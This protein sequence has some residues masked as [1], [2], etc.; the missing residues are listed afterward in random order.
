MFCYSFESPTGMTEQIDNDYDYDNDN[1]FVEHEHET[2][3]RHACE[4]R[5]PGFY[6]KTLLVFKLNQSTHT[7]LLYLN[8]KS[9]R[10]LRLNEMLSSL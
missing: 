5:H 9:L 10:S 4:G 6:S 2:A 8:Y 3:I 1:R 7:D